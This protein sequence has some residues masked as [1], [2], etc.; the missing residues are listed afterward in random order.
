MKRYFI[1]FWNMLRLEFPDVVVCGSGF[2]DIISTTYPN[3]NEIKKNV[4]SRY[5]IPKHDIVRIMPT[6]IIELTEQDYLDWVK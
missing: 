4:L 5:N 3:Q 1:V 2:D 6:N